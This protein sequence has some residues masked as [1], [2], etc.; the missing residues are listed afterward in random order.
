[1]QPTLETLAAL[2]TQLHNVL[3]AA[4]EYNLDN[5]SRSIRNAMTYVQEQIKLI[6]RRDETR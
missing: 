5:A 2:H 6:E 4:R 3:T 1:M